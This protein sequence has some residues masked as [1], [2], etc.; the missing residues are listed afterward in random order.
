MNS[1]RLCLLPAGTA[2]SAPKAKAKSKAKA[3]AKAAATPGVSEVMPK[4]LEDLKTE[5][6]PTL[7]KFDGTQEIDENQTII[8]LL[9]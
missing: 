5:I 6:S 2:P 4:S 9:L 8:L 7:R 3:K 1:T